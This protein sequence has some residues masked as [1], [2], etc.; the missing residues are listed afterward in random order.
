MDD[1]ASEGFLSTLLLWFLTGYPQLCLEGSG[2]LFDSGLNI[3]VF[4][5]FFFDAL[6]SVDDC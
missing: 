1:N 4:F 6:G 2:Q 3:G 5:Y